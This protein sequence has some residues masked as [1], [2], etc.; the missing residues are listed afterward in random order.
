MTFDQYI[1]SRDVLFAI[2]ERQPNALKE[3][4]AGDFA[5]KELAAT[6]WAFIDEFHRQYQE[7]VKN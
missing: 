3:R 6:A 7:K 2:L 5:G 4:P 1:Q